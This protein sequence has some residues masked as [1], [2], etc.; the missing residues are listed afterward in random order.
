MDSGDDIDNEPE[1]IPNDEDCQ[2]LVEQF[3]A[4]TNTDEALAQFYLQDRNWNVRRSVNDYFNNLQEKFA[5]ENNDAIDL[6]EDSDDDGANFVPQSK[7]EQSKKLRIESVTLDSNS[8]EET[9]THAQQGASKEVNKELKEFRFIT[10]NID[11]LNEKN[12]VLRTEAVCKIIEEEKADVVF[13]Q[14]IIPA[15]ETILR[16]KLSNFIGITGRSDEFARLV[17]YYTMIFL[18]KSVVNLVKSEIVNFEDTMMGRNLLIAE[19]I[20]DFI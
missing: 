19:V 6:T 13:L 12:L 15:S 10:W 16:N 11:G 9:S 3:V 2:K 14:E 18:R 4:C 20:I 17:N 5:K 7:N 1:F 8:E